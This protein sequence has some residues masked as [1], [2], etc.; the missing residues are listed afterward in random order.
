[1]SNLLLFS[2]QSETKIVRYMKMLENKDL[3]LVHAMIPLVT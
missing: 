1:M 2:Y 3:S